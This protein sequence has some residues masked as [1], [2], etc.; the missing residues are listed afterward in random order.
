MPRKPKPAAQR[1]AEGRSPGRDSGGRPVR[2][3]PPRPSGE[4]PSMPA[5]LS[6]AVRREWR[7]VAADLAEGDCT[8]M[9]AADAL[10]SYCRTLVRQHEVAAALETEPAGTTTW[11][12]LITTESDLAKRVAAFCSEYFVEPA[13]A[14]DGDEVDF[15]DAD[16]PFATAV[17]DDGTP[18]Q[19][20]TLP[21]G[22]MPKKYFENPNP[23]T[24]PQF[25][26]V[27]EKAMA[28]CAA[29]HPT[30][31]AYQAFRFRRDGAE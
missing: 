18:A 5:G 15:D 22:P 23:P 14:V 25:R 20:R 24:D 17:V 6:T 16:N 19:I 3:T 1:V 10:A 29:N 4:L 31:P 30:D 13:P 9:P 7:R 27:W 28:L 11:R 8:V 21:P 26:G 2:P 12:R